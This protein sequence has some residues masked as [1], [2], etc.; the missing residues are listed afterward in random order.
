[1]SRSGGA[2]VNDLFMRAR[3]WGLRLLVAATGLSLTPSGVLAADLPSLVVEAPPRFAPLAARLQRLNPVAVSAAMDLVGLE[4]AQPP[5]SVTLVSEDSAMA[6]QTPA[7]V[8]GLALV[9]SGRIV[10][11]PDRQISYPHGTLE[12]V[13]L[14][15]L[16]HV[17]VMRVTG[18]HHGPRWF[19]E[20]LAT[21]A[22]GE[23]DLEDGV[24]AFWAGLTAA[25]ISTDQ[26][27][28]LFSQDPASVRTAYLLAESLVRYLMT[29]YGED[30][31]RLILESLSDGLPFVEAVQGA[32]GRSLLE[33]E[34]GFW[35]D[36]LGWRRWVPAAT[37]TAILWVAIV[38]LALV[39]LR[40]QR[41]RAAAVRRRWEEEEKDQVP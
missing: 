9:P 13:L 22:S 39:A 3:A 6:Q 5:I 27:D 32:T 34:Q 36:Q 1:M 33:L 16:T 31:P 10:L 4:D 25:R 18:G 14:H 30:V 26:L 2:Q 12:G 11:F 35:A 29:A 19:E 17:F 41:Q 37:S 28:R 21:V 24:W 8:S 15:E 20:G 23:H 38:M 7:W 40:K